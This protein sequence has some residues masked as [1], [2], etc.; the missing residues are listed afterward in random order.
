MNDLR[1]YGTWRIVVVS[2]IGLL[3]LIFFLYQQTIWYLIGKWNQL[4]DGDYGHGYLVL[5]ISAY[6]IFYNRQRLVDLMP[7]P[8]YRAISVV[9]TACMLWLV[10][11]LVDVEM[12]QAA[13]LLLLV[14][15]LVW[16]VM[17]AQVTRILVFPILY[18][19]FAIPI[20]F[21]LTPVLQELTAEVVF[22][23]IRVLEIPALR[24]ENMIVLPAGRLS[25]EEACSGIRYF[26]AAL[27]LGTLFAYLN[28]VTL[29]DRLIVVLISAG[30]GVLANLLRVFIVV[31]LGYTTEM[32]HPLVRDHLMFGWYLFGG[33]MVVLL[34]IDA[35]IHRVRYTGSNNTVN[36]AVDEA[37]TSD[38]LSGEQASE[39]QGPGSKIP[40]NKT[41]L[42]FIAATLS[43]ALLVFAGPAMV[44]WISNQPSSASYPAQIKLPSM[45]G[46]WSVID[47]GDD[48]WVPIYSGAIEHRMIFKD[49]NNRE[50]H[51]Y[52]GMYPTQKQGEELIYDSN[53]ISDNKVWKTRYERA[54]P[55]NAGS[56]QVLEQI[57]DKK[58]G[59]K[60]LVWYW[61]H[62]A[63]MDTVSKY[64][65]KALQV[66]GLVNGK[67][68]A[69]VVAIATSLGP[70]PENTREIVGRFVAEMGPSLHRVIDDSK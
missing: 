64:Q 63:G 28:Y 13:G 45:T 54:K 8:E 37:V 39:S 30:A 36:L 2:I 15:S 61:Y 19:G 53:R 26:L 41:K 25:I 31:Y 21:P 33:I 29:R 66:L 48:D 59:A 16:T 10:A 65:A 14:L 60:R 44:F 23:L 32:Q 12:L 34:I 50:I 9:L 35:I 27:T 49:E 43:A 55:Y 20:W 38:Q 22:W 17:G 18:I 1:P 4:E 69:S 3:L 5:L 7:C 58:D 52:L 62:V 6:L 57:L 56:Q 70:E 42:S 68:Q 24:I 11:T 40:C 67:R 51:L 47:S 46:E